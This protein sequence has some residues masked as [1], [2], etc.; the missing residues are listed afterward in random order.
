MF[1]EIL[2]FLSQ[3]QHAQAHGQAQANSEV[4]QKNIRIDSNTFLKILNV[5]G[6]VQNGDVIVIDPAKEYTHKVQALKLYCGYSP[7]ENLH[8]QI[9]RAR[10]KA[11]K[12]IY[13]NY[14][15]EIRS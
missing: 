5:A 6:K 4:F 11:K 13:K 12:D 2:D 10:N 3:V 9:V 1:Q 15:I 7:D 14:V 8:D